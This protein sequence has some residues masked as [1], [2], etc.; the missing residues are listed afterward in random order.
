M[1]PANDINFQGSLAYLGEHVTFLSNEMKM[2]VTVSRVF[3]SS[4]KVAKLS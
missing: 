2:E 4:L 1:C 3:K